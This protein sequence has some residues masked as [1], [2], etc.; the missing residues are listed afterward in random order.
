[1]AILVM[2]LC[3]GLGACVTNS[4]LRP[5]APVPL[6][7][8]SADSFSPLVAAPT[9]TPRCED[10][11][12]PALAEGERAVALIYPPPLKRQITVT[13]DGEGVPFRY[14]DVRGDMTT[15][16]D[17]AG[18]RTTI[19]LYLDEGYAVLSNREG[20]GTPEM[21]EVPLAEVLTSPRLGNPRET[22]L[23]VL[24]RCGGAA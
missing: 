7:R 20:T 19:G 2:V 9:S 5:D 1:V 23:E 3:A 22:M 24:D 12:P 13:V 10:R 6:T 8:G 18:D 4:A 11:D 16:V 21:L 17:R 14:V 15:E